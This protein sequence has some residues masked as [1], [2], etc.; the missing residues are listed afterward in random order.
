[1]KKWNPVPFVFLGLFVV[2]I[3]F[4]G[5]SPWFVVNETITR[6]GRDGIL[7]LSL[8]LPI[9][10]GMGI[11]FSMTVG[12]MC[13]QVGLLAVI[14]FQIGTMGGF[15][16]AGLIGVILA[17]AA[18]FLIGKA[19]NRVKGKE[20]IATLVIGMLANAIYQF[21]F[22]VGYGKFLPAFNKEIVL[23][24]GIGVRN[25]VDLA[26]YRNIVD[27]LFVLQMGPV[28]LPIL[29]IVIVLAACGVITYLMRTPFGQRFRAVGQDSGKAELLGVN[30]TRT[31]ILAIVLS[32]IIA[33]I[34]QLIYLQN[35][36]SLNVYTAHGNSDIISAAALL[37][38]GA[39]IKQASVRNVV[40]GVFLFH[41]LF[42]VSPQAG[43]NIFGNA[44][45]GEYFRSFVA[46]GTIAAALIFNIRQKQ[47]VPRGK[48][49][50]E[51]QSIRTGG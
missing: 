19:L 18:G 24:N 29:M 45:L 2:G 44:A 6:F 35:I 14:I 47:H 10:A 46:Y 17:A 33:C 8:I 23:S 12:A 41:S 50:L 36:G 7:V 1:M 9:T 40:L 42:I 11:N 32:T 20:M 15:I 21:V 16:L 30:V 49:I 3:C 13:A 38:G 22:M 43:Q 37:A 27:R 34:G 51:K 48:V 28:K 31:R 25:M 4:S 5:M 26:A 39:T